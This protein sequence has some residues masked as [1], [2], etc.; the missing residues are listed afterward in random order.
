MKIPIPAEQLSDQ[1]LGRVH[2]VGIG[3]AG[4][5]AIALLLHEAG[6]D[7]TGSDARD[8]AV[9]ERLR[10]ASIVCHVGHDARHLADRDTVI[11]STAVQEDNPEIVEAYRR[12]LRVWPRSAG[13]M[14]TMMR[15]RRLA[16][17]GTHGK[18][19]TTAM[20]TFALRAAGV[21]PSFAIGAEVAGLGTNAHRGSGSDFVVEAD[22]S[23]GAFLHY[24]PHAAVVTNVDADHL[25]TWG[26][27]EAY[28]QAFV[29][30]AETVDDF[31]V[32]SADDPGSQRL[33]QALATTAGPAVVT[34]GFA[35]GADVR[36]TEV[37]LAGGSTRFT[38]EA[39]G[40]PPTEVVLA[41]PGRHY[42]ADALLA[43]AMGLRLGHTLT[44]LVAGLARYSGAA[45]RMEAKGEVGGIRVVDSYAHHPTEI[46]AD[47]AAARALAAGGRLVVAFQPHLVSRTRL[48]GARMGQELAAADLVVVAD[49]YLAREAPDPEVTSELVLRTAGVGAVAGGPISSLAAVL[50]PMVRPGD[51]VLTLGA[52]D[53]TTVG[54]AL[55]D[56][57]RESAHE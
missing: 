31:L 41:V 23:D 49:L 5:S 3:G 16:I 20:L 48:F 1:Q 13:L 43:L 21:D 26:S 42:A 44:D 51:L 27:V 6:V 14:A 17:A 4:L 39:A 10:A 7:V 45:R 34:A 50:A 53:I 38:V 15:D 46:A 52:G 33:A 29:A 2:L 56:L 55:L 30:F 40:Q 32:V 8:S 22:E 9:L 18:T 35:P 36:G 24:R 47:L 37:V 19:T 25:D 12:G 28:E 54:P 11:A 57:L